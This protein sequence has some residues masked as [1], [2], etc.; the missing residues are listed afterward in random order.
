GNAAYIMPERD[1]D[2]FRVSP[3][4]KGAKLAKW[5]N[6]HPLLEYVSLPLVEFDNIP[7]RAISTEPPA[8]ELVNS[9]V[10]TLLAAYE[11]ADSRKVALGFEIFPFSGKRSASLS[12]ITLNIFKWISSFSTSRGYLE[13]FSTKPEIVSVEQLD[14]YRG[15][16]GK[17]SF[18]AASQLFNQP[19]L[20]RVKYRDGEQ[21]L[22][23]VNFFDSK[24][25][26]LLISNEIEPSSSP[27][28]SV[29]DEQREALLSVLA[30]L[31]T[32]LLVVD[33]LL[34]VARHVL[35]SRRAV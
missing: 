21:R 4:A 35:L 15:I 5:D 34:V 31:A 27:A 28:S 13:T 24:E 19:G 17:E 11:T 30:L 26:N 10:G 8:L 18:D 29:P 22:L 33:L 20:Y 3:P 25:S 12:I 9:S 23:A 32:V 1:G 6:A 2:W 7:V 14:G 16:I